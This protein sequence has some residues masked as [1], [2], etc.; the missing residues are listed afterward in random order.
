MSYDDAF[1]EFVA[2]RYGRLRR[3]AYF[4]CGDPH[5][6]EDLVQE[7]LTRLYVAWA[8]I[9]DQVAYSHTALTRIF[10]SSRRLRRAS[11]Y[12]TEEVPE[13]AYAD[14]DVTIRMEL[15]RVLAGLGPLDRAIVVLRYLEDRSVDEVAR[16]VHKNPGNVRVRASRAL[17]RLRLLIDDGIAPT[18]AS[19]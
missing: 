19:L 2:E 17:G 11:E 18:E 9:E 8:R 7:T 14:R 10:I 12:A 3:S 4:L 1:R 16:I 5:A 13:A 6:A 15:D